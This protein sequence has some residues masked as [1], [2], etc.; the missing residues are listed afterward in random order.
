[1]PFSK[2]L[3]GSLTNAITGV[4]EFAKRLPFFFE[5]VIF[6]KWLF[7]TLM[8]TFPGRLFQMKCFTIVQRAKLARSAQCHGVNSFGKLTEHY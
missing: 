2:K 6:F 1:M 5:K 7:Q 3:A 8:K 4:V